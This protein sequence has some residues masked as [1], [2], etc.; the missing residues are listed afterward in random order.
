MDAG[1]NDI[2]SWSSLWDVASKDE[3]G[4]AVSGDVM[5]IDTKNSLVRADDKFVA[6]IGVDD[7]MVISTK[8][9]TLVA[10]K[11]R[12]QDAKI[13]ATK[14]KQMEGPSGSFTVRYIVPGQVRLR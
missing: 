5:L 3:L 2:G 12:V 8:D 10:S 7:A 14:L 1:W 9:A 11:E 13:I 6:L 4:N